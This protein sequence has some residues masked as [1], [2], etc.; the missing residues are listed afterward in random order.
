MIRKNEIDASVF[1][2]H[3]RDPGNPATG[4]RVRAGGL[5]DGTAQDRGGTGRRCADSRPGAGCAARRPDVY[6]R[7]IDVEVDRGIVHLGGYVWE[8]EDFRNARRDAASVPGVK[9]VLT[10]MELMRGGI[11]G[12]GR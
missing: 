4:G 3:D 7:H 2:G 6:A 12:S 11:G 10:E 1:Q 8:I 5:F 9:M